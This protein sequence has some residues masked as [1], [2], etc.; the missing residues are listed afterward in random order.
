MKKRIITILV[1]LTLLLQMM[2]LTTFAAT[3]AFSVSKTNVKTGEQFTVSFKHPKAQTISSYD[4]TVS[5]DKNNFE[6]VS[7]DE[8]TAYKSAAP[9]VESIRNNGKIQL[10]YTDNSNDA[11]T[12][13]E[14]GMIYFTITFKAK[15]T[16]TIGSYDFTVDTFS[17]GGPYDVDAGM[18]ED[19]TPT[20]IEI[21]SKTIQVTV[22]SELTGTLNIVDLETP[23]KNAI[24]DTDVT[25]PA[26]TSATV[27]WYKDSTEHTDAFAGETQYKAVINIKPNTANYYVFS[28]SIGFTVDGSSGGWT[29]EKQSDGSYNLTKTFPATAGKNE[30]GGSVSIDGDAKYGVILTAKTDSL[31]GNG[32]TLSPTFNYQWYRGE[33]EIPSATNNTYQLGEND[34]GQIIKVR[35][36]A[37]SN[38]GYK[39]A[40]TGTN[41]AK[42]DGP[43]AP[44]APTVKDA[45]VNGF[46]Y[47]SVVG[48]QYAVTTSTENPEEAEW[49][50]K[51]TTGG[52][53][54]LTNKVSNTTY[55][56]HTRIAET[57]TTKA[58]ASSYNTIKTLKQPG[59]SEFT[60]T[61]NS[62]NYTGS[63]NPATVTSAV[64]NGHFTLKY[65]GETEVPTDA[66]AYTLTASIT[67]HDDYA[68]D[69]VELGLWTIEQAQITVNWSNTT[70]TY[71]ESAQAPT[72]AYQS[73][74]V[75]GETVNIAV[76][77][78]S[79]KTNASDSPY[80]A[81]V[82]IT[83]VTGGQARKENYIISD[84][85]KT[86]TF[87]IGKADSTVTTTPTA[88]SGLIY[89]GN[90]LV[91]INEGEVTGGELQYSL[92]SG[93]GYS[94]DIPTGTDAKGYTVYYRVIGDANHKDITE[95]TVTGINI[96]QATLGGADI[97]EN[98]RYSDTD[99][100]NYTAADFNLSIAGTFSLNGSVTDSGN[101]LDTGYPIYGSDIK[102]KLK[103]SL[104]L[105]EPAQTVIIPVEFTPA[106]TNY[107]AKTY[108]LTITLD[109]KNNVSS[110]IT[111]A[112]GE[113]TYTGEGQTFE[114][115]TISG[116]SGG[117]WTYSYNVSGTGTLD[118]SSKPL[119]VG[120]YTVKAV[121][122]DAGNYGEKTATLTIKK[123][124]P[125]GTPAYTPITASGKKL[126]DAGLSLGTITPAGGTISWDLG[127]TTDVVANTEYAWT[128]IPASADQ[129]NYNNLKGNI[130]LWTVSSGGG[131]YLPPA[132][133]PTITS[134]EGVK[135]TLSADGTVATIK[136]DAGYELVDVVLNGTSKGKATEVKGLKTG[137]KLVVTAAKKAPEPAEPTAEEIIA[138]LADHKLA[139]RSKVVTMKNG[140]KAV[141]ITWYNANGEM[142][143]FDGVE[144]F[145]STK[146]NSGYGKKPF[147][148]TK[149][150]KSKGYYINTKD[151]K[152]GTTYYYKLRGYV[153]IDGQKYYTDYSLKAIRTVK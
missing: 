58:G 105:A 56:V 139:A 151:V 136:V 62:A 144:I 12:N 45:T 37:D 132:Q 96:A 49:E 7:I 28:D 126:S 152:V 83:S 43:A 53:K 131:G 40:T 133:K 140:K 10:G 72:V 69:T 4:L 60:Y 92:T 82:E 5:F 79:K 90:P 138:T 20:D 78:E 39:E 135:V 123:A 75:G 47:T 2:P 109:D 54:I 127:E 57:D 66:G 71:N 124:T 141:R 64:H 106:N 129:A 34:I 117:T 142:M 46:T 103:S 35:V 26:N 99:E 30:L 100:K 3:P 25:S 107:A 86:K 74:A 76:T 91:L 97:A 6:P 110:N 89:T 143:E 67:A 61:V 59:T 113:L 19:I 80:I 31:Y 111:F 42:A 137:D 153:V 148:A 128:Y 84:A 36:T 146:K 101:V 88:K 108:T 81:T 63:E 38:S 130:K 149:E 9:T 120:T 102:I 93:T 73:G 87:T 13:I 98:V 41:V 118:G 134:G 125:T 145:R 33:T 95:Q 1:V 23:Q 44:V 55:Y 8:T 52:D 17:V 29:T 24:P 150:S 15:E 119:T 115:A 70:L 121:Y 85:T 51:I 112:D 114:T 14:E 18:A 22:V 48:Q 116:V 32:E 27:K 50:A 65:N 94:T 68:A 104:S 122:E 77:E 16:A 21:G 147:Y 11:N